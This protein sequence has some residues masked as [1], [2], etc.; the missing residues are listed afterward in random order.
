MARLFWFRVM[1][2]AALD[3]PF[4][5]ILSDLTELAQRVIDQVRDG[6]DLSSIEQSVLQGLEASAEGR[7]QLSQM[8]ELGRVPKN[9]AEVVADVLSQVEQKL[10][11][12]QGCTMRRSASLHRGQQDDADPFAREAEQ[13]AAQARTGLGLDWLIQA[14]KRTESLEAGIVE[15]RGANKSGTSPEP[16]VL[17]L[18]RT[19]L[20]VARRVI[21]SAVVELDESE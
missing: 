13:L 3:R 1:V 19:R 17:D 7:D 5:Q 11:F 18:P 20:L 8:L 14:Y 16:R 21:G 9:E 4:P 12:F 10:A 15:L 2:V 6:S